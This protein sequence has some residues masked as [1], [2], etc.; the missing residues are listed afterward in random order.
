MAGLVLAPALMGLFALPA[1]HPRAQPGLTDPKE[2][3]QFARPVVVFTVAL[4]L[5]MN[6]DLF[7][8]KAAGIS[9][10]GIGLYAAAATVAK[11]PYQVLSAL[12][13][14]LLPVLS[15]SSQGTNAQRATLRNALRGLL[16]ASFLIA[17]TLVSALVRH[18]THALRLGLR[19]GR[20]AARPAARL[21]H[22]VHL[23]LRGLVRALRHR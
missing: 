9:S 1:L 19:R 10:E 15:S 18:S 7:A 20:A 8:V 4:V 11:M 23:V 3:S 14:V 2:L 12:G 13:V 16:L 17:G 22:A 6:L 5:L 21:R